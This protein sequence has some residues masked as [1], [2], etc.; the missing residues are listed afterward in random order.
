MRKIKFCFLLLLV[1]W[2]VAPAAYAWQ[3]YVVKVLD[4]D[5]IRVRRGSKVIEVRLYGIDCPEWKQAYGNRARKYTKARL[6]HQAVS[7]EPMDVDR[8]ARVVALVSTSGRLVNRELV[9]DG[10][11]WM[12]PKYCRR[13]P[14]C[15]EL[16]RLESEARSRRLGLWKDPDPVSPWP[17]KHDNKY[18]GSKT[19]KY[20]YPGSRN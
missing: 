7:V 16:G 8:Y 20:R 15:S 9:R 5:S 11:A 13:E 6:E 1:G 12:Y 18:S 2:F 19:R 4:G 17:W 10:F 3:G 14:L